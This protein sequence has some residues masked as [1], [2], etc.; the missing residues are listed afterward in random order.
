MAGSL[1]MA[2][3]WARVGRALKKD[4][5]KSG[6]AA[7]LP[8]T[9]RKNGDFLFQGNTVISSRTPVRIRNHFASPL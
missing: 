5:G 3:N 1:P 4:T 8:I 2:G 6:K 9:G 7:A